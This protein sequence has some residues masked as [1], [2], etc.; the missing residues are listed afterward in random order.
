MR[1]LVLLL[2]VFSSCTSIKKAKVLTQSSA[3]SKSI[4]ETK[5]DSVAVL[6]T[7]EELSKETVVDTKEEVTEEVIQKPVVVKVN[8]QEQVVFA[9]TTFVKRKIDKLEKTNEDSLNTLDSKTSESNSSREKDKDLS[10]MKDKDVEKESEGMNPLEML[11]E[12]VLGKWGKY[13]LGA[14]ALVSTLLG[15]WIKF[16]SIKNTTDEDSKTNTE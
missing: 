15:L 13:V 2:I 7:V 16:K 12:G 3:S 9:T 6:T 8:G 1:W 14:I 4:V 11:L 10:L 5:S